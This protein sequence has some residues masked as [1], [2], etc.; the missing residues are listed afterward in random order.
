MNR[1][2]ENQLTEELVS[3]I[4]I[5]SLAPSGKK[6]SFS[7]SSP[8]A[9]NGGLFSR[10][11]ESADKSKRVPNYSARPVAFRDRDHLPANFRLSRRNR[12]LAL[13]DGIRAGWSG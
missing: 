6:P 8:L 13:T 10:H 7:I 4:K 12:K 2:S 3:E 1:H 11:A 5:P 9:Q